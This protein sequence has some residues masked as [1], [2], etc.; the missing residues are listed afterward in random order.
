[1][2]KGRV[3][4]QQFDV[5]QP[6]RNDHDVERPL[7]DHLIGDLQIT[8]ACVTS[9]RNVHWARHYPRPPHPGAQRDLCAPALTRQARISNVCDQ[10]SA[11]DDRQLRAP[12]EAR[13]LLRPGGSD[14]LAVLSRRAWTS[15]EARVTMA[16][17][18]TL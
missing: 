11:L 12:A 2:R 1:M 17:A 13:L 15:P 9:L 7:T 18:R 16:L 14:R 8:A 5:R 4:P 6:R 10:A 3:L